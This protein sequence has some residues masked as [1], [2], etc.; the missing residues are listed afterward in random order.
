MIDARSLRGATVHTPEP[1]LRARAVLPFFTRALDVRV[2]L[3]V[4]SNRLLVTS[5][6]PQAA[7]VG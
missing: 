7:P 2:L 6:L 4:H 5:E 3:I 1:T